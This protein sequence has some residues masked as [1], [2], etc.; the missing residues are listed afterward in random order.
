MVGSETS[1]ERDRIEHVL[2]SLVIR[3]YER[4]LRGTPATLADLALDLDLAEHEV[5]M[6]TTTLAELRLVRATGDRLAAMSPEA[7]EVELIGPL[8]QSIHGQYRKLAVLREQL[9][10]LSTTFDNV[11]RSRRKEEVVV[12]A[13]TARETRLRLAEVARRCRFEVLTMQPGGGRDPEQLDDATP[14]DLEML[15]REVRMRIIYQHTARTDIP[16]RNYVRQVVEHGAEVRTSNE[17]FD[18][19]II[20]DR[21]IAFVPQRAAAEFE[22]G[23]TIIYEPT[24]VGLLCNIYDHIWRS[25]T[26]FDLNE[27]AYGET[28]DDVRMTILELLAAGL[29]D[30][31]IARRLGMSSRT[32]RRH[33]STLMLELRANSR[34]QAGVAASRS[35]LLPDATERPTP[36]NDGGPTSSATRSPSTDA[37]ESSGLAGGAVTRP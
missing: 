1:R 12:V 36:E 21:E 6:A 5:E 30:D 28:L 24:I 11:R 17:I 2:D 34:F 33:I 23:A 37:T 26:E 20:F 3:V 22:P 9:D 15:D 25:A 31:V 19:M 27:T 13:R 14:R 35:G 7:A 10:Q 32:C 29:K 4:L 8:E 16:T 18:R